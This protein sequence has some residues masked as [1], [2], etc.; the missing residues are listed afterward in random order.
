MACIFALHELDTK[1][2]KDTVKVKMA[3]AFKLFILEKSVLEFVF[4][5][6]KGI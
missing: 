2:T 3:A 4:K 1:D 6:R 5:A